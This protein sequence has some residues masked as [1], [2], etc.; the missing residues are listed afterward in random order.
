MSTPQTA[1]EPRH[2]IATPALPGAGLPSD[3][4][5]RM[6]ARR[7]FVALKL[8]FENAVRDVADQHGE[9]LRQQVRS[10]EQPTDLW[11]LR[12]PVFAALAGAAA[13]QRARRHALRRGIEVLFPDS[14][15]PSGFLPF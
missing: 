3:R 4:I 13:E 10:A 12:A 9:W 7:A 1:V 15:P 5:A 8:V 14:E 11:L 6:A 2:F